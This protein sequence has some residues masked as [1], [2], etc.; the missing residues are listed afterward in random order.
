MK[1]HLFVQKCQKKKKN[2]K[3]LC[4]VINTK[5]TGFA[6]LQANPYC[7]IHNSLVNQTFTEQLSVNSC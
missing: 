3:K 2:P 6:C 1:S 4:F 7:C 5:I